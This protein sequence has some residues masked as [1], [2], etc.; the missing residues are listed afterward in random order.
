MSATSASP[1][2]SRCIRCRF[3]YIALPGSTPDNA[4]C[5]RLSQAQHGAALFPQQPPPALC[6]LQI[7]GARRS[8]TTGFLRCRLR[9]FRG[10]FSDFCQWH[11]MYRRGHCFR[12][13]PQRED[14]TTSSSK[15]PPLDSQSRVAQSQLQSLDK[16]ILISRQTALITIG[17][18]FQVLDRTAAGFGD[19]FGEVSRLPEEG[20]SRLAARD[21]CRPLLFKMVGAGTRSSVS[22]SCQPPLLVIDE[23]AADD[24]PDLAIAFPWK[25]LGWVLC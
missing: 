3:F 11:G 1:S 24:A 13:S 8:R 9:C 25:S 12:A 14:L 6:L 22:S 21:R 18:R 17:R 23:V 5:I 19:D 4:N 7:A 20:I 2:T 15:L 16:L 10:Q